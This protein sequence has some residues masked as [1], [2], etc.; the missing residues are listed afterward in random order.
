MLKVPSGFAF[1]VAAI[2]LSGLYS[3]TVTGLLA[4]TCPVNVAD[5]G[6]AVGIAE[7]VTNPTIVTFVGM[8][9]IL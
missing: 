2:E 3:V 6:T 5:V 8:D 4:S 9:N 1:A 7:G